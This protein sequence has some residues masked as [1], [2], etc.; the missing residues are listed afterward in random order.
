MDQLVSAQPSLIL[1]MAGCL[2][3]LRIWG[4]TI[5]VS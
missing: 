4:A 5:F 3:N 1:Q 2:R